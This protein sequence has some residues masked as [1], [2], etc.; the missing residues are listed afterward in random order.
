MPQKRKPTNPTSPYHLTGRCINRDWFDRP[1][2]EVWQLMCENL[3]YIKNIFNINLYAFVLM[4]NH[5][6]LLARSP[7]DNFSEGMHFFMGETARSLRFSSQ[8]IN[9]VWGGPHFRTEIN[10]FDNFQSAY[11]YV[12]RNPVKAG[13]CDR[14]EEYP[15]SSLQNLIQCNLSDLP[16]EYDE[17]FYDSNKQTME[18]LNTPVDEVDWNLVKNAL[19]RPQFKV[20]KDTSSNKP[21]D[22]FKI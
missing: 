9:R 14:V 8:R 19:R 18:W 20:A 22:T 12:Y 6:H 4:Q 2:S 3:W 13:L 5:F 11:K 21:F 16:L 7:D 15:Y 1:M 17:Q 10:S